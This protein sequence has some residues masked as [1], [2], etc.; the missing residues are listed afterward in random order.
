MENEILSYQG[1]LVVLREENSKLK[2]KNI[3]QRRTI[4][5]L[6]HE[7][8]KWNK[9]TS[10]K[11]RL[12]AKILE[13]EQNSENSPTNKMNSSKNVNG[14]SL[15][16]R[17]LLRDK[18]IL[19]L[20]E[21]H[22]QYESEVLDL[23]LSFSEEAEELQLSISAMAQNLIK[24]QQHWQ[25]KLKDLLEVV[26]EKETEIQELE[27]K[28]E[29]WASPQSEKSDNSYYRTKN[30]ALKTNLKNKE[31]YVDELE[32][33]IKVLI[34]QSENSQSQGWGMTCGKDHLAKKIEVLQRRCNEETQN[35]LLYKKKYVKMSRC[36]QYLGVTAS[37]LQKASE[38]S[39]YKN[40]LDVISVSELSSNLP[41]SH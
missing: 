35:S 34:K 5:Q 24:T 2:N 19:K 11:D 41:H 4:V 1:E 38:K 39:S 3:I 32:K 29:V 6:Q 37:D 18:Y 21:I 13:G 36:M 9:S 10:F 31:K 12:I 27:E 20:E 33:R 15:N 16:I 7:V 25:E 40:N 8:K 30:N 17:T 14:S 28:L 26:C 22:S 23:K